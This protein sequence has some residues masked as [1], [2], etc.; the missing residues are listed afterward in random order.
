MSKRRITPKPGNAYEPPDKHGIR[1]TSSPP[2]KTSP[3]LT[4]EPHSTHRPANARFLGSTSV[5]PPGEQ[6]CC[7]RS[8]PWLS[9]KARRAFAFIPG[10]GTHRWRAVSIVPR[11]WSAPG[12]LRRGGFR[13]GFGFGRRRSDAP[14]TFPLAIASALFRV[15]RQDAIPTAPRGEVARDVEVGRA[16]PRARR[17]PSRPP[18]PTASQHNAS[19]SSCAFARQPCSRRRARRHRCPDGVAPS[20]KTDRPDD[21]R[22][23]FALNRP[24]RRHPRG[25]PGASLFPVIA[26]TLLLFSPPR[27]ARTVTVGDLRVPTVPR[28]SPTHKRMLRRSR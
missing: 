9:G 10:G 24:S 14:V 3:P 5:I 22:C 18:A 26:S 12:R 8:Q 28:P 20:P 11:R 1:P 13:R 23:G 7:P 4:E 17:Q 2:T 21:T 25:H 6:G 15:R 19:A 27:R 16:L